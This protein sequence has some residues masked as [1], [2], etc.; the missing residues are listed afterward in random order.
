MH[1]LH[2]LH[3][4]AERSQNVF[5]PFY[6]NPPIRKKKP[7]EVLTSVQRDLGSYT[8]KDALDFAAASLSWK[9]L[10]ADYLLS[11]PRLDHKIR[12]LTMQDGIR[13]YYRVIAERPDSY[14]LTA[15]HVNI[16]GHHRGDL[17]F[18]EVNDCTG[19]NGLENCSLIGKLYLG[20]VLAVTGMARLRKFEDF[21][22]FKSSEDANC[23][24]MATNVRV[25]PRTILRG[26][27]FSVLENQTA[28]V[29]EQNEV[30]NIKMGSTLQPDKLYT[31]DAFL[32]EP[33]TQFFTREHRDEHKN[34]LIAK[35]SKINQYPNP[36]GTIFHFEDSY[37]LSRI[38][39]VGL[40]AFTPSAH[41]YSPET[42]IETCVLMGYA[43]A[44]SISNGRFDAR[45]F[46]MYGTERKE[47]IVKFSID[48]P[49]DNPT[50]GKWTT[51]SRIRISGPPARDDHSRNTV[52]NA[53]IE[54]VIIDQKSKQLKI[55][56]R[57]ARDT[58]KSIKF[59]NGVHIVCQRE[60]LEAQ[61]LKKGFF[62]E[63]PVGS[64]GRRIIEALYGGTPIFTTNSYYTPVQ[65]YY[66][67]DP[68]QIKLNKYQC[69]YVDMLLDKNPIVVG[70]SPF[71]CGK[72]MTIITAALEICKNN[73]TRHTLNPYFNKKQKQLLVTQS[74]YA[75]VNLVEIAQK[76]IE[77][78]KFVR[79]VSEK[80]WKELPE[81]CLTQSDLPRLMK[82]EF[83]LWAFG[84]SESNKLEKKHTTNIISFLLAENL[85]GPEDFEG[86]AFRA[87][88]SSF[89]K[90]VPWF[91]DLME[92][93]FILYDPDIIMT[94][95]DSLQGLMNAEFFKTIPIST[96]QIDEASQVPEYTL[97]G[98][99][100]SFP[101]ACFGLIGDINQLPPYCETGLE[102]KLKDYGI[103][104]TMEKAV[105][106]QLF[107]QA[108]LREVYRCH[109]K[110]TGLLSEL[111]YDGKLISGVQ[112]QTR[113]QFLRSRPDFWPSVNFPVMIVNNR[114]RGQKMGTSY[115]NKHEKDIV[116][117]ILDSLE[118]PY[119]DYQ[120]PAS[121]I[122][123]ISFYSAQTSILTE[124]LRGRKV[125]CGTVDAF[126]GS[127][128]EV[129]VLCCTNEKI[130][131]FMQLG[132]R[133]NVAMSRAKQAT[134]IVGNLNGLKK[135]KYWGRIVQEVMENGCAI[136]A[137]CIGKLS[138]A[139]TQTRNR[140]RSNRSR[141]NLNVL[142]Q[143][144]VPTSNPA[145][146]A[147]NLVL[148]LPPVPQPVEQLAEQVEAMTVTTPPI[149]AKELV[150]NLRLQ[151]ELEDAKKAV[152]AMKAEKEKMKSE[153]EKVQ[154]KEWNICE[155]CLLP[156][157]QGVADRTP[158]IL[159][160]G[161]TFCQEC[162]GQMARNGSIICG[163]CRA[164]TNSSA[165]KL[166]TNF[167]IYKHV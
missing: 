54:T 131:E 7:N 83:I 34:S 99:L 165:D 106:G 85:V 73:Q 108:M 105:E 143:Q 66:P 147:P 61:V 16:H 133:L 119:N 88:N 151:K 69:E 27:T 52:I 146:L 17:R 76:L 167:A 43:A 38:F 115:S 90:K 60:A 142:F 158:K 129:V 32:P 155:I 141:R 82:T 107:P 36:L 145:V 130:S 70:S 98:L 47:Q 102:G 89:K 103:G 80:N 22:V 39:D 50:H 152:E 41:Y 91:Y 48:N 33:I 117:Q 8:H 81:D 46:P 20:D 120:L 4:D 94:T 126:Q 53:V 104:N 128:K 154:E 159:D 68:Q 144:A 21:D 30:M 75:S 109:P 139:R 161:H 138:P 12:H 77:P 135:A 134:I 49:P 65:Y 160:C 93:F 5:T 19:A 51:N 35:C 25:L 132:N 136:E 112:E 23:I 10:T 55:T 44:I 95:S 150:V 96:I 57:L 86:Q 40:K 163:H 64:N 71:G 127:E 153:M 58:P 59:D 56:A 100:T 124:A 13:A 45:P 78:L 79:Y 72:S 37:E 125:K 122:G 164:S 29:K 28:V 137:D 67:V 157:E 6:R 121:D 74:N 101:K 62:S 18:I 63:T 9:N 15:C 97:I 123:V 42:V 84:R 162:A 118:K 1:H 116:K 24:W 2:S 149:S 92:A 111:F 156:Y 140:S 166:K 113:N 3:V 114:A 87:Y 148:K 14:I 11:L 31:G 110:T 26:V